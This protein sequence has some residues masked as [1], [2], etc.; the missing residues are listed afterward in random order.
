MLTERSSELNRLRYDQEVLA[1]R[2][3]GELASDVVQR[4]AE[5]YFRP[6]S[7]NLSWAHLEGE[8]KFQKTLRSLYF[9]SPL[10]ETPQFI[11]EA[12]L[13]NT[14]LS[15]VELARLS[16]AEDEHECGSVVMAALRQML[17]ED[18]RK[19]LGYDAETHLFRKKNLVVEEDDAELRRGLR[20][21]TLDLDGPLLEGWQGCEK[22]F[23]RIGVLDDARHVRILSLALPMPG[24][25]EIRSGMFGAVIPARGFLA[26]IV[27]PALSRWTQQRG[28]LPRHGLRVVDQS[29]TVVLPAAA[30]DADETLRTGSAL[31]SEALLGMGS[32][33]RLEVVALSGFDLDSI[34]RENRQWALA[35]VLSALLLALGAVLL[36]RG[37]LHHR[38][39]AML[40]SHLMGNISHELKTPL[41]LIRLY[42]E[43]LESGRTHDEEERTRFLRVI[44][45][46]SKRLTHLIDNLLDVQ[47]IESDRKQYSYAQVRPGRVIRQTVDSYRYQLTEAGFD[48]K[49]DVDEELPLLYVDEE[50]LAQALINLLDNA[51]KYSDTVKEIRVACVARHEEVRISVQDRGIGI[52]ADE[53]ARIFESF[54]RVEKSNVHDVKGSGLGLAVVKHVAEHHG[55]R[56]DLDSTPGKGSTFT[57]VL[58]LAF[59]PGRD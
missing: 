9:S 59:D 1:A 14:R 54:Y 43:T 56:V 31:Y 42:A 55:G 5:E 52:P 49:L 17:V 28:S 38:G 48:L 12:E 39:D 36:A 4:A 34:R 53:R 44:G 51:A 47:R 6:R 40:R 35:L 2:Y 50:A 19:R 30:A 10:L 3:A 25:G 46:E 27:A 33:W 29:G 24:R 11:E 58:P 7:E 20:W 8:E 13:R 32:P 15:P 37:F 16:I 23:A 21:W 22:D 57:I 26:K 45:R 18:G 41:S